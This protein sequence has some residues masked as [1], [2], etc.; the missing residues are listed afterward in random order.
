MLC[1]LFK[2]SCYKKYIGVVDLDDSLDSQNLNNQIHTS[3]I[4][5]KGCLV[6][7]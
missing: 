3:F 1:T 2:V 5:W 7:T 4:S 6:D